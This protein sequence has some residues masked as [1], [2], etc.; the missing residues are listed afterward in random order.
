LGDLAS[1]IFDEFATLV[2]RFLVSNAASFKGLCFPNAI[3]RCSVKA[4][5]RLPAV[6]H[7]FSATMSDMPATL[8]HGA[9]NILLAGFNQHAGPF[10]RLPPQDGIWRFAFIAAERHMNAA[11]SVHGGMLMSFADI[12]MS[13]SSRAASG[14]QSCST[15][16]LNCDF[17]G[18][19]RLGDLV[20]AR[21]GLTRRTRTLVFLSAE[22]LASERMV[23]VAN[24]LWKIA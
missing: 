3:L 9:E 15:I 18:P 13:Q 24:G 1:P 2:W 5:I 17:V 20:E 23:M 11:G 4:R 8:P 7:V 21:V 6:S 14:A 22:L 16:S 12:A 19:A 10:Y